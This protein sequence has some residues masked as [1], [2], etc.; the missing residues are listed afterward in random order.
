MPSPF[1]ITIV[2]LSFFTLL[3]GQQQDT[4]TARRDTLIRIT[5]IPE[6]GS[7]DPFG[8]VRTVI[9]EREIIYTDYRSLYDVIARM[10]GVF[11]RDLASAGQQNQLF[12]NGIDGTNIAILVDGIPY[13][14]H[15]TGTYNLWQLIPDAVERVEFISGTEAIFYDGRSGG[16]AINIVTKNFDNNRAV[17]RLRYSQGVAGYT[18][19]DAMFAQNIMNGVNLSFAL[20][21]YGFGSGKGSANYRARFINSNTDSWNFRSKL[22]Y[23]ITNSFNL[24]LSYS[25]DRTWTGLHGGVDLLTSTS[26]FDG[27]EASVLNSES[28]EKQF[29]SHYQLTAAY[30]PFADSLLTATMSVYSFD[31]LRE[32]RDEENRGLVT[33]TLY[34][35]R[36]LA[37]LGRGTKLQL[38]S[39]FSGV[40]FTGYADLKRVQSQDIITA[41]AKGELFSGS[42]VTVTGFG[43][44]VQR[45]NHFTAHAGARG[46]FSFTPA[47]Q[48]FGGYTQNLIGDRQGSMSSAAN[49]VYAD[50]ST[51]TFSVIEAGLQVNAGPSFTGGLTAQMTTETN[52]VLF[53]TL[54]DFS[55]TFGSGWYYFPE[56]HRVSSLTAFGHITVD[57]FHIEGSGTILQL[58]SWSRNGT[59]LTVMPELTLRGSIY[60]EGLLAKGALDLRAGVRG[61]YVSRQTGMRPL[62]EFGVWIPSTELRFGP[63]GTVDLF[64]VGK[65]GDAFVH[66]IWENITNTDYLLA[67]VY[68]MYQR[69]VRFGVSWEFLD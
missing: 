59:T 52:P 69:N 8:G 37:S 34:V 3:A 58:P 44:A 41:G 17:T 35:Q 51:E 54:T 25:Y 10:P 64:A 60:F 43:T 48:M 31:R 26:L 16:G 7:V 1:R 28:F 62:D 55:G 24:S 63:S 21:H 56:G 9:P 53:D 11:V 18:Q 36:D 39:H 67:P 23:N 32:Y 45:P 46:I 42:A 68:P 33:N 15:N 12:I 61:M 6:L 50:R 20:S 57:E 30:F 29:N 19:T 66:L 4:T 47:V 22:R 2:L 49:M 5:P 13:N 65:I 14:D 38:F 27:L 40:R